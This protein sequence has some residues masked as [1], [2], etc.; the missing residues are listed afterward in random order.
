MTVFEYS[1]IGH[2][3]SNQDYVK[4]C[5]LSVEGASLHVVSDGMGG[6]SY[7][8]VAAK[9]VTEA[10]IDYISE[11]IS[12]QKP[13]ALLKSA[14]V[15]ANES[16]SIKR[17]SLGVQ[18]M[19]CVTVALLIFDDVVYMA[20]L[21]DSRI[22]MYRDNAEVFRTKDHSMVEELAAVKS[23]TA[24]DL[25]KY[26]AI[27]TKAIMGDNEDVI[28][29]LMKAEIKPG[30]V[31]ILCTDGLYKQMNMPE[32]SSLPEKALL[33]VLDT[34]NDEMTDNYSFIRISI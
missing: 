25:E 20:W 33:S 29:D 14:Y 4:S 24:E 28:P 23:L 6:Y 8:E 9:V 31:F 18:E 21:G 11:N 30:D 27:V 15:F 2:R 26:S 22:Y 7:G 32:I 13:A 12:K 34:C 10:I 17:M 16:L 5:T 19:G 1:N 3:T